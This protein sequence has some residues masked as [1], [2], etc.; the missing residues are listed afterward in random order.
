MLRMMF[1]HLSHVLTRLDAPRTRLLRANESTTL[2]T[3]LPA[4]RP[5]FA[6]EAGEDMLRANEISSATKTRAL[7]SIVYKSFHIDEEQQREINCC[8]AA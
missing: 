2:K 4:E 5:L 8:C 7:N 1:L 3:L 6:A